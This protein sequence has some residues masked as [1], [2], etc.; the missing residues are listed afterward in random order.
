[1]CKIDFDMIGQDLIVRGWVGSGN[2][3]SRNCL[4][5][6]VMQITQSDTWTWTHRSSGGYFV[7]TAYNLLVHYEEIKDSLVKE[8]LEI[9]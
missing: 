9:G 6:I 1:M 2:V 5:N 3:E 4:T 8:I 7:S